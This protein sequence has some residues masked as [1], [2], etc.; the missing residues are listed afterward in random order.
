MS[1]GGIPSWTAASI[2]AA[3]EFY[4]AV[5]T[6]NTKQ[7]MHGQD[8]QWHRP[9]YILWLL[10]FDYRYMWLSQYNCMEIT[11]K[12]VYSGMSNRAWLTAGPHWTHGMVKDILRLRDTRST[13]YQ[14]VGWPQTEHAL[15]WQRIKCLR[16]NHAMH[17]TW[18]ITIKKLIWKGVSSTRRNRYINWT[19]VK[20]DGYYTIQY[21]FHFLGS[22]VWKL[23]S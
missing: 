23:K 10:I 14:C 12:S 19:Q 1:E 8:K 17:V 2:Y 11:Y 20:V 3:P 13:L 6:P 15:T 21:L 22:S 16:H 7:Q 5:Q 4:R 9:N 18:L